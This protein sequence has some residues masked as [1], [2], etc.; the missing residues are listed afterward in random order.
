MKIPISFILILA[1]IPAAKAQE[2]Y[3]AK[4][5]GS[6]VSVGATFSGFD[7]AYGQQHLGGA[8][9][10]VDANL[11]RRF[12]VEAEARTLNLHTQESLRQSTYL[13]GPRF[14]SHGGLIRPYV[15]LLAGRGTMRF[16]FDYAQ[17]SYFVVQPGTG[18]DVQAGHSRVT[19]R[20]FDFEYQYWQG[21]TFGPMH[22]YG[23]SSGISVRVR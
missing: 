22:P 23:I 3:A 12:G 16:P 20:V 9:V 1:L 13:L 5:P 8:T 2:I 15:A 7:S 17:G 19:V 11:Y 6:Y 10:F 18:L 14:S 4:G 21:F